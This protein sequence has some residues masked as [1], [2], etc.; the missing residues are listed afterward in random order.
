MRLFVTF[1][2]ESETLYRTFRPIN[3]YEKMVEKLEE[4][5]TELEEDMKDTGWTGRT[6]TLKFKTD[7]FQGKSS[8]HQQM[9]LLIANSSL[10]KG[11]IAHSLGH[12]E[13]RAFERKP[14]VSY[15]DDF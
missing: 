3:S 11:K 4:I 14:P 5:A 2:A 1:C 13:G 10:H 12:K 8:F 15:H 9:R 7:T 6:V